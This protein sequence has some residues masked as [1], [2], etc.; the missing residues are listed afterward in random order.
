MIELD[1]REVARFRAAVRRC[2]AG[3]PRGLELPV[4]LEQ[5]KGG[6]MLSAVL[7]ETAIALRLPAASE[8]NER[9]VV[10]FSTLATVEGP[11]GGVATFE[12]TANGSIHCRWQ[13]RAERRELDCEPV[14]AEKQP[15]AQSPVGKLHNADPSLLAALH[16]CGQTAGQESGGRFALARVQL[17]GQR[18]EVAGTD[19]RQLLLWGGFAFPF[20]DDLLVPAV[21]VF[22]SGPFAGEPDVRIGRTAKQVV[23]AMGRGRSG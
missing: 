21:P 20:Q 1:R 19:G 4:V 15:P 13:D 8:R 23:V 10:P 17:R 14:P 5:S 2:V 11:G 12:T 18:G 22:G 3:R 16:A 6:L 9:L 7:E